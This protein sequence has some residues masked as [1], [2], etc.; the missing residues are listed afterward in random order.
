MDINFPPTYKYDLNSERYDTSSKCRVPSWTVS[1][2]NNSYDFSVTTS[3]STLTYL[4]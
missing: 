1:F 2:P 3:A 4:Q